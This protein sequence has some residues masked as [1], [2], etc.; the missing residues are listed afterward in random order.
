MFLPTHVIRMI[1]SLSS[2]DVRIPLQVINRLPDTP[3]PFQRP[4]IEYD[5]QCD[6]YNIVLYITKHKYYN[7]SYSCNRNKVFCLVIKR[8]N[9]RFIDKFIGTESFISYDLSIYEEFIKE[10]DRLTINW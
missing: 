4:C 5:N 2:M 1:V 9:V 7:I 8:E 10:D 6:M 3:R